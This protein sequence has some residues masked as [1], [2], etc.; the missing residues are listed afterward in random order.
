[1]ITDPSQRDILR[2][3]ANNELEI[4]DFERLL[5][6]LKSMGMSATHQ[7]S[8]QKNF[9]DYMFKRVTDQRRIRHTKE[10]RI[11]KFRHK[12]FLPG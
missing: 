2:W 7:D 4:P 12:Y 5:E 8:L 9:N 6:K 10:P 3:G 1:I 11:V